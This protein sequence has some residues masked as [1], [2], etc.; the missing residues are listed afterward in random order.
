MTPKA[1]PGKGASTI[2][3]QPPLPVSDSNAHVHAFALAMGAAA[4][5]VLLTNVAVM[6]SQPP[7]ASWQLVAWSIA[8]VAGFAAL[9]RLA[10]S[11]VWRGHRITTALTEVAVYLG[12]VA[13]SPVL[14][15]VLAPLVRAGLHFATRRPPVKGIFNVAQCVLSTAAGAVVFSA[16]TLA[17]VHPLLAGIAG[18]AAFSVTGDALLALLFSLIERVPARHVY[19][20]RF[21]SANAL[22]VAT[23][24]PGAVALLALYE[25]HPLAL[26]A[27]APVFLILFRHARLQA[28]ADRELAVRR[29][30]AADSRN[31]IGIQA[32]DT[33]AAHVFTSCRELLD[34]SRVRMRMA[35]GHVYEDAFEPATARPEPM[36]AEVHG[37]DGRLIATLEVWERPL[38]PRYGDDERA[39]LHLVAGQAAHAFESAGALAQVAAQRDL[40]ARQEKLSSLGTLLAGVAHEVNNP[41]TY[42]RL[43][44][45]VLRQDATKLANAPGA[46]DDVK[47]LSDKTLKSL[48]VLQKGVE[49]LAGLSHSLKVVA[50]PGDGQR[51]DTDLNEVVQQVM[52][53]MTAAEKGVRYEVALAP[54]IAPI[55]ANAAELHQVVLN[56][57]K[58]AIEALEGR[59]DPRLRVSTRLEGSRAVVLVEDNGPGI[60][61]DAR[62]RLFT[63]FFTT[64]SKGTGLGLS[65]SNQ[66]IV[67]HGGTLAFESALGRGTTFRIELPI[68]GSQDEQVDAQMPAPSLA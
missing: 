21:L 33:I 38:K 18:T 6:A 31:L 5:V 65:I 68:R 62:A 9:E 45:Q 53:V 50:R 7:L 25:L 34:P 35:D 44:I 3:R 29:R 52:T 27:A 1:H 66:I 22:G 46:S 8:F 12:Y 10:V 4:L 55:H 47:A 24:V 11:F 14:V 16:L 59:E 39:L 49:R 15:V 60:P 61:T 26:V 13:L 64:K 36:S 57:V 23:G 37:R 41:L 43:R 30:L 48:D 42:M 32:E 67:A 58:N 19:R 56:L 40:I 17:G 2:S 54:G 28:L 63:P 20:E 51:H